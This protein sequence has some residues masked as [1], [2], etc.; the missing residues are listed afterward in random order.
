MQNGK[1]LENHF[2]FCIFIATMLSGFEDLHRI[3]DRGPQN[4]KRKVINLMDEFQAKRLVNLYA[5]MILRISYQ[6]LKQTCDAEDI[7]QGVFLKYLTHDL[8]FESTEHEKAWIIRT[9]I[10]TCKDH[11]RSAFFRRTVPLEDAA[12]VASPAVPDSWILEAMKTLPEK[13]RISL[14]L[15]YYEE[16]SARE[17]ADLMGTSE[18]SVNQYLSRGRRKLRSILT[19]EERRVS[20]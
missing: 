1:W 14:Y 10:N 5:D 13:Q 6:Y 17:I 18:A 20:L 16:Y 8:S 4:A 3:I 12:A 11:L 9:T 19:D 7:C 2:T 15:Y